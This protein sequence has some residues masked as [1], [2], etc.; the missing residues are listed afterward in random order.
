MRP[1]ATLTANSH[2]MKLGNKFVLV[3]IDSESEVSG[4]QEA[5]V[6][7]QFLPALSSIARMRIPI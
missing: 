3:D 2:G 1:R 7:S 6:S 4:P 5:E